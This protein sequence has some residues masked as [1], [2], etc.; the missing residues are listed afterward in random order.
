MTAVHVVVPEGIDEPMRPSGGNVYDRKVCDGLAALGWSVKEHPARGAWPASDRAARATLAALLSG[1]SDGELV[2]VDGLIA[3]ALP[4]VIVP[5]V[6]RLRLVIVLHMPLG[7]MSAQAAELER[8]V[9]S[10]VAAVVTT[11]QWTRRWVLDHYALRSERVHV[12]EP[13]AEI[14]DLASG[15]PSGGSL[16]CVG[17]VKPAKGHDVLVMALATLQDLQWHCTCV[18]AVDLDARFVERIRAQAAESRIAGRL[19]FL[20]PLK[21]SDLDSAYN[22]ADVLVSAS[23]AETYGMV[24]TEALARGLPVVAT[25]VGGVPE[26]LDGSTDTTR[27]GLLV[28]PGDPNGL[29]AA[30]REWLEDGDQRQR[31]RKAAQARRLALS[32]WD[33]TA[34]RLARVLDMVASGDRSP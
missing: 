34:R 25:N 6:D 22:S 33:H 12:A 32:D 7:G 28:A 10:N 4:D 18:G 17:A 5:E 15:T 13:G 11:S 8:S 30:L 9:L 21:D 27:P 19:S 29:A 31:L 26:A 2:V 23:R 20:G 14:T 3:S 1:V 16:L 24:V